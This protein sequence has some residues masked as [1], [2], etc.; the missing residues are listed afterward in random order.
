MAYQHTVGEDLSTGGQFCKA[1]GIYHLIIEDVKHPATKSDGSLI[2]NGEFSLAMRIFNG[3]TPGQENKTVDE[4]Y[5]YPKAE[6]TDKARAMNQKKKDRL[7]LATSLIS[8]EHAGKSVAFELADMKG[9]QMVAKFELS[10]DQKYLNF[11]YADIWHVDDP[12]VKDVVANPIS[13]EALKHYPAQYRRI[14]QRSTAAPA[15]P[16]PGS[17]NVD[18]V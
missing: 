16:K 3:T 11:A 9:R 7:F 14:G 18:D 12:E 6:A 13:Q 1:P 5:F 15:P 17:V 10:D 8:P 4:T 2:S